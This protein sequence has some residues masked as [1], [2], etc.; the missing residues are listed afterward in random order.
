MTNSAQHL[1]SHTKKPPK[2]PRRW[3][4]W[5]GVIFLLLAILALY[6]GAIVYAGLQEGNL[7]RET[8][9]QET[10]EADL[11]RQITLAEQDVNA[12]NYER[13]I[14]RLTYVLENQS[15]VATQFSQHAQTLKAQ[16][17]QQRDLQLTP[18]P[19]SAPPT[20][21]LIPT[22]TPTPE[23]IEAL[24][25]LQQLVADEQWVPAIAAIIN[26]Q[27]ANPNYHRQETDQ[28]L[29]TSYVNYGIELLYGEQVEQGIFYLEQAERLGTLPQEAQDTRSWAE[30]YLA[31]IAYYGVNWQ[32]AIPYFADLCLSAPFYQNACDLLYEARVAYGDQL[33]AIKDYCP[34]EAYYT[35]AWRQNSG[36]AINQKRIEASEEC[37]QATQTPTITPQPTPSNTPTPDQIGE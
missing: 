27:S 20:P 28:Y 26:F 9:I 6:F 11:Q 1:S 7:L 16:A 4:R 2:K 22:I 29:F 18:T 14:Q 17:E 33:V 23:P 24:N 15:S 8:Y 36:N 10:V 3:L 21:T 31:G 32:V 19:T 13:A 34:A 5:F 30:L 25:S 12:G 37:R 35:D